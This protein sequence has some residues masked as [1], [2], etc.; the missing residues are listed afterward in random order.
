MTHRAEVQPNLLVIGGQL[1]AIGTGL[2][3]AIVCAKVVLRAGQV[4]AA[5]QLG[6]AQHIIHSYKWA[7]HRA[8][9]HLCGVDT[10]QHQVRAALTVLSPA[11]G[12]LVPSGL[13][14]LSGMATQP[15]SPAPLR[16]MASQA[17]LVHFV[18]AGT[19]S[20]FTMEMEAARW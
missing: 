11:D 5:N 2:L 9:E 7:V 12:S 6:S 18:S 10:E 19:L 17:S 16:C 15:W 8:S 20:Q 3:G 14:N 13:A 4:H 1:D